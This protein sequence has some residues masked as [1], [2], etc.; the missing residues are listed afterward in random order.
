[1]SP[2]LTDLSFSPPSQRL[3]LF[4]LL[5]LQAYMFAL[6]FM[7]NSLHVIILPA[8]LLTM[9]PENL[10]NTA[11]GLLTFTG[12]IVAMVMQPLA[13]AISDRWISPWGRRRP[14][15][16][17]GT[18]FDLIFLAF[19]AW[20]GGLVW[21]AIGYI[22]LQFS[23]NL[24]H[25]A[26]QGLVP[27]QVPQEQLGSASALK[28]FMDM[29][30]LIAA[31]LLMGRIVAP[32]TRHPFEA[33]GLVALVLLIGVATTILGVHERPSVARQSG[34]SRRTLADEFRIDW[35]VNRNYAW[36]IASRLFFLISIYG[37]QV[38]AQ[39][40]VRDVLAVVNPVKLTGDLLAA[41]TLSLVAFSLVGGWLGDRIGHKR[42]SYLACLIGGFGCFLLIWATTPTLLLA[43]G[44]IF[45]VG[46]GLFL[47]ANWALANELAPLAEAGKFLGL[48]NLATAG[49]GAI[50]RLEGPFIDLLNNAFPGAWWGY[51]GLFLV[52]TIC[53]VLSAL[54]LTKVRVVSIPG[55]KRA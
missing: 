49:A 40:Y 29:T 24:A 38:F 20:A 4:Q 1:M 41:I 5:A 16:T 9:V 2:D 18:A 37:V 48:T 39:Y 14:M 11:L 3:S 30:G 44:I 19:L 53:I 43:Y 47:T 50:G 27:D 42:V 23:S 28:N 17:L 35:N 26:M 8:V 46:I 10:K 22:G 52:G 33:V 45:G 31:S 32:D 12:L 21:L 25:G 51:A 7:W 6:S 15:I 54:L 36:L 34:E 13:G 55:Q